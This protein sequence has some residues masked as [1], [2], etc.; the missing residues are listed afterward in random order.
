MQRGGGPACSRGVTNTR[1][2]QKMGPTEWVLLL[3]LSVV[4]GGA[5]FF[6]KILD[7]AG[8]PPFTIVLGRVGLAAIVLLIVVVATR[9]AIPRDP[10]VWI[11][12]F[13]LG[14]LNNVIPF[15]L[16]ILAEKQIGSGLASIFNATTPI[17]TALIAQW[18]TRDEKLSA[19]RIAGIAL[20]LAG[21]VLLMGASALH[22]LDLRSL[23]QL[24]S[25]LAAVAYGCAAV[26]ARRFQRLGIDP[27]VTS[28]GQLLASIV[29]TVPLVLMF[30]QSWT[31]HALPS[32]AWWAWIG[33]ALPSTALA[34]VFYFRILATAGATNAAAVTFL[35]PISAVLLGT[36]F[37]GERLAPTT[38][39]GM[40]LIFAG[41][42]ALDGRIFSAWR[43]DRAGGG[44]AAPDT[45]SR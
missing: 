45:T 4:W 36:F 24:A 26:Y 30:G 37:L 31:V 21:V 15:T 20:G 16:I 42:A 1:A 11:A 40:A 23:A 19:A 22:G 18:F 6:Y 33:L 39:A 41:L 17:F 29:L 32:G 14:V 27:L 35:V 8:L 28:T 7:D 38:F 44:P 43:R 9:R 3:L 13:V 25:V 2:V 10:Q 12:F 34:Y 5:F